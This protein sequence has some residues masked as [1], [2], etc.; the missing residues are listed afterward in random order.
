MPLLLAIPF[1]A[2]PVTL[3]GTTSLPD[4]PGSKVIGEKQD[5]SRRCTAPPEIVCGCGTNSTGAPVAGST[6]EVVYPH[7]G[8]VVAE[9]MILPYNDGE[10]DENPFRRPEGPT[11]HG[12]IFE[13]ALSAA[14]EGLHPKLAL[15]APNRASRLARGCLHVFLDGQA[16]GQPTPVK[17][18]LPSDELTAAAAAYHDAQFGSTPSKV[19]FAKLAGMSSAESR[20]AIMQDGDGSGPLSV[21][22]R[23]AGTVWRDASRGPEDMAWLSLYLAGVSPGEHVVEFRVFPGGA[24]HFDNTGHDQDS[25]SFLAA[26]ARFTLAG[27][28]YVRG[29]PDG[30]AR[31][32]RG[33]PWGDTRKQ[34]GIGLGY[35]YRGGIGGFNAGQISMCVLTGYPRGARTSLANSL[36]SW[37]EQVSGCRHDGSMSMGISLALLVPLCC[38]CDPRVPPQ[39][40]MWAV[41]ELIVLIQHAEDQDEAWLRRLIA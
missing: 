27:D 8:A 12:V 4:P 33:E 1:F 10:K 20:C 3:D 19:L 39:G 22:E 36:Q 6:L 26:K 17:G 25:T 7:D 37:C 30:T 38:S 34:E 9:S 15:P 40:L 31:V 32:V 5:M 29:L 35:G 28:E 24:L 41:D 21:R 23:R 14:A 18:G 11:R 13:L 16:W 2:I